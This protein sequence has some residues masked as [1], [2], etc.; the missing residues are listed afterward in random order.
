MT[1]RRCARQA[2][3]LLFCAL[4]FALALTPLAGAIV[5]PNI[6]ATAALLAD[7]ESGMILYEKNARERRYPASTTKVMTALVVL[8]RCRDLDV[9]VEVLEEDFNGV[10]S[11]ASKAGF[12]V[13]EI[14]TLHDLLYGLMLP[15]GN[16]AANILARHVAGSVDAFVELMNAEAAALGCTGTHFANPNGLHNDDH[17]TTAYDLYLITSRAMEDETFCEIANTAQKTLQATNLQQARKVYTTNMLIFNRSYDC[18]YAY[19]KGVKTGY[20]SHA[21]YCLVSAA[22][23]KGSRL[24][25]VVMGCERGDKTYYSSFYETKRLFEWG[26]ENFASKT[27]LKQNEEVQSVA[28]RLSTQSD[29]LV[30]IAQ[31]E[32]TATV[33]ID[34]EPEHMERIVEAPESVDAPIKA[35]DKL[36]TVTLQYNGVTY[37]SADLVALSDVTLSEVLYY[38]DKLENFFR[39]PVF[40]IGLLVL[41]VLLILYIFL[42]I[43]R[44][45]NRRARR[46]RRTRQRRLEQYEREDLERRRREDATTPVTRRPE[47]R[48]RRPDDRNRRR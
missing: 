28:V 14:V 24:I 1:A 2:L 6:Q 17:Y 22:E 33:P 38:A 20:T 31:S 12:K 21:G 46:T 16:E 15:S 37:G 30:L 48:T 42:Y 11:D 45:R 19:C 5:D 7:P 35:G 41:V 8:E 4:F 36:G 39:S 18:Y 26:Y 9:T 3:A 13:G 43:V 29:Q 32:I 34:V 23:R 27:L 25:S 47:E 44:E 40:R 10:A